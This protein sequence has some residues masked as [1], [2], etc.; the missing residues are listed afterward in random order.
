MTIDLSVMLLGI[1]IGAALAVLFVYLYIRNLVLKV[2]QELGEHI[3]QVSES[4]VPVTIERDNGLLYCYNQADHQFICQGTT[5]KEIRAAFHQ[6]FPDKTAYL[7]GGEE[8]LVEELR[9]ELKKL[10]L[11]EVTDENSISK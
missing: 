10:K 7:A 5:M 4:L 9:E 11:Q 6:R 3:D 2:M 1:L 8:T